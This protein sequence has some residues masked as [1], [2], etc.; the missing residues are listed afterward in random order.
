MATFADFQSGVANR[1]QDAAQKLAQPAIDEC[2]REAL[3]GRYSKARPRV[4]IKDLAGDGATQKWTLDATNFPEWA[5][6]FSI[7]VELEYPAGEQVPDI[8]EKEDWFVYRLSSTA[9]ELRLA[10]LKPASGKT[11]R[12]KYTAPHK[13]DASTVS[14]P[15]FYGAA[16][17]A[18]ALAAWRLHAVYN[19]LGDPAFGADAVNYQG[20]AAEYRQLARDLEERF[21]EAFGIDVEERQPAA[22]GVAEWET[23][24]QEGSGR[25]TH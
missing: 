12:V 2:I 14:D 13:D 8:L 22:T 3:R 4:L 1:I 16:S 15:D 18:A 25:L 21:K 6:F 10:S 20:K 19:Q 11:L 23:N 17:L 24:L 7:I 5:N 9:E